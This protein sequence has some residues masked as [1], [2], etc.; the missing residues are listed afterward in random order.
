MNF[1]QSKEGYLAAAVDHLTYNAC[2]RAMPSE[3]RRHSLGNRSIG[4]RSI[5]TRRTSG[6]LY[7]KRI[8]EIY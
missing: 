6:S 1:E 4:N 3:W 8:R 2:N 7:N 5:G